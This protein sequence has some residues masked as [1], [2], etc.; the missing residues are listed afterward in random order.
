MVSREETLIKLQSKAP[1]EVDTPER[2]AARKAMIDEKDNL[3]L[4]RLIGQND[5]FPMHYLERGLLAGKSVCRIVIKDEGGRT[6]GFGTGFLVTPKLLLTNNHVFPNT[7]TA[8]KS[9]AQFNYEL[10][11]HFNARVVQEYRFQP[12]K[13]F[14]TSKELDFTLIAVQDTSASGVNIQEFGYLPLIKQKG[15]V[16][17]GEYVSI[18]Q[19]PRGDY[20]AVVLRENKI[21]DMLDDFIHYSADTEPGSSGST[22]FN[23]E[24]KVVA[25][26]HS[27]VP[28]PNHEGQFI[29]NEGVRISSI[30]HYIEQQKPSLSEKQQELIKELGEDIESTPTSQ[31]QKENTDNE[32]IVAEDFALERFE[33]LAGYNPQFLGDNHTVPHPTLRTDIK[34]DAAELNGGGGNILNYTH[35]SIVMSKSR[36]LAFY[37]VVNIDGKQLKNIGRDDNWRYDPRIDRDYQIGNELYKRNPLDRGHLVRRRDPIWG[38]DA[39]T[40]NEDTFHFTNC[41][42]QH[43]LLNQG[44]SM[45]L[46]LEDYIL[47]HTKNNSLKATIFTGPV[48][49]ENDI[50]YRGV[51]IPEEFWKVAV[52]VK[53]DGEL[54]ATAYLVSQKQLISN[55]E[56]AAFGAFLTFQVKVSMIEALTGLNFGEL[57]NHDPLEQSESTTLGQLLERVEDIRI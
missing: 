11:I 57:H 7:E 20:K 27:G 9:S 50:L 10:D 42:P 8:S 1:A 22:V 30:L 16:L 33:S 3:A 35:F 55:L 44:K 52:M 51:K 32:D 39:A 14:I 47:N 21:T 46:G 43:E 6:L 53:D 18:I 4:E 41:S 26:H 17:L 34:S 28:D 45:W 48:F 40:A 36:R 54:S 31:P 2:V 12:D 15:K 56:A 25:L 19:H 37:T 24:W 38:T 13:L 29:A 49:R 5:M 23:D